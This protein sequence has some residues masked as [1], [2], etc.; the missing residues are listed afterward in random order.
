MANLELSAVI[1]L[2][3]RMSEPL[4]RV[5]LPLERTQ[6]AFENAQNAVRDFERQSRQLQSLSNHRERFSQLSTQL[7]QAQDRL[8]GLRQAM[9]STQ[10]PSQTLI[11]RMQTAERAVLNLSQ[12]MEREGEIIDRLT[13]ELSQA[14]L[15]TSD[16]AVAQ[17]RL[18]QATTR[19]TSELNRQETALQRQVRIR[20]QLERSQ[21]KWQ[22]LMNGGFKVAGLGALGLSVPVREYATAEEAAMSLK[23]AMMNNKGQVAPEFAQI[24]ALAERLG[25]SLPGSTAE[26]SQM[27]S[28][29][30][31]QGIS[32]KDILGGVGEASANLAVVMKMP[33]A[34]AA[35]FAA[36]MQ[37]ATKTSADDMLALMDTIQ[38][39]YY[40]GVD[41]TNMLSGFSK[42]A[43]GMKTVRM[44]GLEGAKAL[45]PLL[46][47]ADQTGMAGET[48]GGAYSAIFKAMMD[49][50]KINK[51][52]K[53]SKTGIAMNFT[54]GKG[55]FGGLDN[56]FKQLEKLKGMTTEQRLSLLADVFGDNDE[57]NQA[58]NL[59]IDKGKA[60]YDETIAKMQ[61]QADLQQRV[62][63]QLSTLTNLWDSAKGA[64]S[65]VMVTFGEALAPDIKNLIGFLSDITNNIGEFAKANPTATATIIKLVA[66]VTL[67]AGALA[68][69][70]GFML[71]ILGPLALL[72]ASL[73]TLQGFGL[74]TGILTKLGTAFMWLV[75]VV[76]AVGLAMMA[77]PILA[78]IAVIAMGAIYIWRNWETLGPK[79]TALWNTITAGAQ[80]LW[81][82]IVAIWNNLKMSVMNIANSLWSG[83]GIR[84]NSGIMALVAIILAFSP[85][86][87]FMRVFMA[88][89]NY[90]S[91]LGSRFRTYGANII[92]GL[93][94][95]IM[96]K[97]NSV[98]ASIQNVAN[99]IKS[100]FTSAMSIHSPS[101]VFMGYGDDIM[102]GL[103]NG[104]TANSSPIA[105]MLSTAD[106]LKGAL[107]TSQ[108][109]FDNSQPIHTAQGTQAT[110]RAVAPI[111]INIYPQP[112][113][114]PSD[115]ATQVANELARLG[116]G[117]PT[118]T[119]L[120]DYAQE[121]G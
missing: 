84:F 4:N 57:T 88:V 17:Q 52:L 1:E 33:F 68:T 19:A 94:N 23:V 30:V 36:K 75:G 95:G 26:F 79:F 72:R 38:K 46:I 97:L 107:D 45:A 109:H 96:S 71:T 47:M 120:Y 32:F 87:L 112:N 41:S 60:G 18:D 105:T 22:S 116:V 61:A 108:I 2:I 93:K 59:L 81:G 9:A 102:Q 77:N 56:M 55:E 25:T 80:A 62:N 78:V 35:E 118:G 40:L 58:L 15:E 14:G 69:L 50:Q 92:E 99:R 86:G 10:N 121:W 114:N 106:T 42:L 8:N 34:E 103:D 44:E 63:A 70:A 24:N 66:G 73:T 43:D 20:E 39:S 115:I 28:T 74:L 117:K 83:L 13:N 48:A 64:F 89:W 21:Q 85:A 76:R 5:Q 101:R 49:T 7:E 53:D 37:D 16:L 11:N 27:M 100:A 31:Q 104:L 91:T 113:Q 119:A 29:L 90:F 54:D 12:S 67:L 3:D 6:E 82:R 98:L 110:E 65:S 51:A 111:S